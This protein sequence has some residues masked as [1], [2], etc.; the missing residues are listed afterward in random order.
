MSTKSEPIPDQSGFMEC[1]RGRQSTLHHAAY[2]RMANQG[3][4]NQTSTALAP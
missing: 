3:Y 2:M 1:Y 4:F